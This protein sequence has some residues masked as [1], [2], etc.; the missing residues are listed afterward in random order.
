MKL[1]IVMMIA[2]FLIILFDEIPFIKS[3]GYNDIFDIIGL[4]L[5]LTG[6]VMIWILIIQKKIKIRRN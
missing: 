1:Y 4:T 6:T 5:N 2:G 3:L